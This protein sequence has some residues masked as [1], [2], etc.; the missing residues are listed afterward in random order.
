MLRLPEDKAFH[1]EEGVV[2]ELDPDL[3]VTLD[4]RPQIEAARS[5]MNQEVA[6]RTSGEDHAGRL[7]ELVPLLDWEHIYFDL[8]EFKRM[9]VLNLAL[10]VKYP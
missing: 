8:L 3:R 2:L 7:K 5:D 9:R 1:R 6:G 4:L 10:P